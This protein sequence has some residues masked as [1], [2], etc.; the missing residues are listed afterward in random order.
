VF[1]LEGVLVD[2]EFLP[3]LA[4]LRGKGMEVWDITHKGI[5]GEIEWEK[6]LMMR[7]NEVKGASYAECIQVSDNLPLMPSAKNVCIELRNRGFQ[8]AAIS[9]GFS[10]LA[11]RVQKELGLDYVFANEL[12]FMKDIL[13][14][15]N[16]RVTANKAN[17]IQNLVKNLG[18][19][20]NNIIAVVD[21]ANDL[22]LF[23]LAGL[24]IAFC[25]QPIVEAHSDV[26]VRKKDL[27]YILPYVFEYLNDHERSSIQ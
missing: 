14:S 15:V 21:G 26:I 17:S 7:I 13:E 8:I 18:E 6:G 19:P 2:G 27:R 25:A 20:R 10:L 9:G 12:V 4:N 22:T 1:D 16:I 23:D 24:R 11:N 5:R 3:E